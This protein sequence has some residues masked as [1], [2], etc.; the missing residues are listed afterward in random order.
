ME[1]QVVA[2]LLLYGSKDQRCAAKENIS[3]IGAYRR[4]KRAC[5]Q[6]KLAAG[7]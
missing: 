5:L 3:F 6:D 7:A 4:R 1:S 2:E